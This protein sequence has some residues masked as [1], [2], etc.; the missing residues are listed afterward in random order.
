MFA[1]VRER[2]GIATDA[3]ARDEPFPGMIPG[4][5]GWRGIALLFVVVGHWYFSQVTFTWAAMQMFFALSGFLITNGLLRARNQPLGQYVRTFYWRRALRICPSYYLYLLVLSFIT[6]FVPIKGTGPLEIVFSATYVYNFYHASAYFVPS[7]TLSHFWSLAVEEQFYLL[8]PLLIYYAPRER[9][10]GILWAVVAAG[11]VLRALTY[12]FYRTTTLPVL[13]KPALAIYVLPWTH[14]DAFA[15]GALISVFAIKASRRLSW[16]VIAIT[17]ALGLLQ[18]RFF[19]ATRMRSLGYPF[20]LGEGYQ[21]VWGYTAINLCSAFFLARI[22]RGQFL[23]RLF[24]NSVMS[25][26]GRISY[27]IYIIHYSIQDCLQTALPAV[28]KPIL[29]VVE[30]TFAVAVSALSYRYVE[31]PMLA[32]KNRGPGRVASPARV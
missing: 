8:W 7:Y 28:P 20:T 23:P 6:L 32:L 3:V 13:A 17:G 5:D 14:F 18:L 21:F 19:P 15:S 16:L 22:A 11:P 31:A 24:E 2:S 12:L 27:T 29:I 26:L 1:P 10:R 30:L 4:L 25:A 9:L